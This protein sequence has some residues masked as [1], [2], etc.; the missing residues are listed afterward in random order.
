MIYQFGKVGTLFKYKGISV[1][2]GG[3][4][5]T[6]LPKLAWWWPINWILT[7]VALPLILYKVLIKREESNK[8]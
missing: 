2:I 5:T 6:D 7:I 4:R 8:N 3:K 1:F